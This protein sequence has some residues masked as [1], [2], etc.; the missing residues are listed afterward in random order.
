[1]GCNVKLSGKQ[2]EA[3]KGRNLAILVKVLIGTW[4]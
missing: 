2:A 3:E 4:L 1:M